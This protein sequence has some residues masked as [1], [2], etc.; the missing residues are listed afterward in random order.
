MRNAAPHWLAVACTLL[1]VQ[2]LEA[3]EAEPSL[4]DDALAA[5][6]QAATFFRERV[7]RHGG[8]AY[9]AS[10]DLQE[11]WGEGRVSVD[12]ILVQPPGTPTVGM[13]FLGAFEATGDRFYLDAARDAAGA[14][15]YG[16][17]ESGGWTQVIDFGAADGRRQGKYRNGRGGD[18]NASS[19]DDGQ[20]QS[21][22]Q[23]LIR[24]DQALG[25]AD[26]K[27]HEAAV[28]GLDAL[29]AAQFPNG[30]FPQVWR[31]PVGSPSVVKASY[32]EYDWKT[33]GRIKNYWDHYNLNDNIAGHVADALILAHEVYGEERYKRALAKLADFLILAQMPQP[34]PGWCQQYSFEM[35]PLW[36][37]R[38]EPPAIT[39]SESQD[40]MKTLIKV[41]RYTGA[42]KYLEPISRALAYFRASLLPDGRVARFYELKTNRPLYMDGEYRLTYDD[43]AA[44]SHYG[45]KVAARFDAIE[46][47]YEDARN[48]VPLVKAP[49]RVPSEAEVK[50][51]LDG[52]DGAGR[53][54]STSAGE[55]L[56]GQPRL[57]DAFRY[58]SSEV[59]ALRLITLSRHVAAQ[60]K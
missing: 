22:L 43:S 47:E 34:Q 14:L 60:R 35:V 40:V 49:E 18:W 45:W 21:A 51:I 44:P 38:F 13:A 8:Y 2:S 17:L 7:A 27:I 10:L 5:M 33:E 19:L 32:P 54:V 37:R 23:F 1:W 58:I 31:G 39:G 46:R 9:Y 16:Q 4:R 52:L 24:M 42:K 20:T 55:R 28:Y 56:V 12:T 29:L 59:F 26:A 36:A 53:W 30:G 57:G 41:A 6:K 15:V 3:E 50:A 25:L 11:R 48:G